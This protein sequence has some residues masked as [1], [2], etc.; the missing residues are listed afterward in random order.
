MQ[1]YKIENGAIVACDKASATIFLVTASSETN[2]QEM[3]KS[4]KFD[5]YDLESSLDPDEISRIEFNDDL[6]MLIVKVPKKAVVKENIR[7]EVS[8]AGIFLEKEKVTFILDSGTI[9][10]GSKVFLGVTSITDVVLRFLLM[11]VHHFVQH[12]KVIKQIT[13]EIQYKINSSMENKYLLQ[14][15]DLGE[16]LIYYIHSIESN[17]SVIAKLNH[18]PGKMKLSEDQIERLSDTLLE[19]QQCA[20]QSTIYSSVLSGLMDA[21]GNIINNNMNV[22][23][24]KLTLINVVFLPL[25][26]VAGILGMSEYSVM[27]KHLDWRI[28]YSVFMVAMVFLGW[29]SWVLIVRIIDRQ[30]K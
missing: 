30:P 26:L 5:K 1:T 17:G 16:S 11:T 8:S 4:L 3:F 15:F 27:T 12:L 24:K 6:T 13:S 19:N 10:F 2:R 25:N 9:E 28:S 14:M 22:L 7:F 20:K 21:R 18:N 23:L 29:I